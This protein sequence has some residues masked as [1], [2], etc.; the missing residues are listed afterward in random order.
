MHGKGSSYKI[1]TSRHW[2]LSIEEDTNEE[3][4]DCW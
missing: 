4:A 1:I 3:I 2:F